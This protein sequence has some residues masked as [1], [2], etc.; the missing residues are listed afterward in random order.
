MNKI[1][2]RRNFLKF[3]LTTG[4]G[5]IALG[6]VGARALAATCG[7]TPPQ[8]PG[9]FYPGEVN[10]HPTNDLT[11][12]QG[13]TRRASGRVVYVVGQV[14]DPGCRP[15]AGANVEIWQACESGRYNNSNDPNT[16]PLDPNFRY[17]GE[18]DT[19]AEGRYQF[20]TIIPGAYPADTNWI[21]PPH[22]HY[23]VSRR[24]FK[25]LITQMYFKEAKDLNDKDL[26]LQDV[27]ANQRGS[28][29]VDFVPSRPDLEPGTTTGTF[30]ITLVPVRG[31]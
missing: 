18:T 16:A 4:A 22:I 7:L 3:G 25:D 5:A 17:W 11:I 2:D 19:D 30:N 12:I 28:V 23:K 21:R 6:G 8:T 10:F 13:G 26:I 31:A 1:L 9:P 24:G 27:P 14:L 29:I 15:V 20:K